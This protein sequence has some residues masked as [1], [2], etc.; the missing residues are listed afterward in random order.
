MKIREKLIEFFTKN[1]YPKDDEVHKLAEDL[2][3]PPDEL[4]TEIYALLTDFFAMGKFNENSKTV[5]PEQLKMGIKVEME[6]TFEPLIA[7]RIAKDHLV[8]ISNYYTK[9]K[10]MESESKKISMRELFMKEALKKKSIDCI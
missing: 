1:K 3:I 2:G 10:K 5:D 9:L 6:H 7:E 8:E 4:E